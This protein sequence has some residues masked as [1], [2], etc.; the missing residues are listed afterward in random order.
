MASLLLL[1]EDQD[2]RAESR[3]TFATAYIPLGLTVHLATGDVYVSHQGKDHRLRDTDGD[4][5]A[6]VQE[7]LS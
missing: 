5:K 7:L 2:G 6:D 1:D 3:F 4:N